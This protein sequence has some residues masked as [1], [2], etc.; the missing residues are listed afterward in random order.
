MQRNESHARFVDERLE[1]IIEI[2]GKAVGVTGRIDEEINIVSSFIDSFENIIIPL[3]IEFVMHWSDGEMKSAAVAESA[4]GQVSSNEGITKTNL[5]EA[6]GEF[7]PDSEV[8]QLLT[9]VRLKRCKTRLR[10]SDG[11]HWLEAGSSRFRVFDGETPDGEAPAD[12]FTISIFD[13]DPFTD[14]PTEYEVYLRSNTDI[15]FEDTQVGQTNRRRL[16]E[17]IRNFVETTNAN[18]VVT[19]DET[20][21]AS[22]LIDDGLQINWM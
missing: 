6:I 14:G 19:H 22:S 1:W 13:K 8:S 3:E 15:W 2:P 9:R 21:N 16:I 20:I 4:T 12:V 10:L 17:G 18:K 7:V 11:D 5:L